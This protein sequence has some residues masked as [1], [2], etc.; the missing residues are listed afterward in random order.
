MNVPK[1]MY[2]QQCQDIEE[3]SDAFV[4]AARNGINIDSSYQQ[5]KILATLGFEY[6]DFTDGEWNEIIDKVRSRLYL[7]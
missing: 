3:V 7:K 2:M 1:M 4:A 5:R 6:D